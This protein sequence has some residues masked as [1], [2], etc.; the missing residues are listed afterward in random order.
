MTEAAKI[1]LDFKAS[2]KRGMDRRLWHGG[3]RWIIATGLPAPH[4]ALRHP[5]AAGV[6]DSRI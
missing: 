2:P 4:T 1:V 5:A 3:H 6:V